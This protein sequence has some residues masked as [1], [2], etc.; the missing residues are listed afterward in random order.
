MA[1]DFLGI[2]ARDQL[3]VQ[4]WVYSLWHSLD[5]GNVS[6]STSGLEPFLGHELEAWNAPLTREQVRDQTSD[7][8]VYLLDQGPVIGDGDSAGR[9]VGDKAVICRLGPSRAERPRP[10]Q[11]L[12][13]EFRAEKA[14]AAGADPA[15]S[16][17]AAREA[18]TT[19]RTIEEALVPLIGSAAPAMARLFRDA[20]PPPAASP[21]PPAATSP[22]LRRA[23]GFGRKGL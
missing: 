11:A 10:V 4:L 21:A 22:P 9:A 16:S 19:P 3:P 14:T 20:A 5:D 1:G 12:C 2:L 6:V 17:S 23:G 15:E 7:L 13:L 8:I 18:G